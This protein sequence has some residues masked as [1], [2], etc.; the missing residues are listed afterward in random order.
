M[1]KSQT[2]TLLYGPSNSEVNTARPTFVIF[3]KDR[4]LEVKR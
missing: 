2:E 4:T 1:G 3:H